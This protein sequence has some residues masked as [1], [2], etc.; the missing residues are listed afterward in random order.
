M[1]C[2]NKAITGQIADPGDLAVAFVLLIIATLTIKAIIAAKLHSLIIS[3]A[4][5]IF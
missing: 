4:F 3:V 5:Q 2:S 1:D